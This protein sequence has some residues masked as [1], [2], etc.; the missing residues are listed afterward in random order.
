MERKRA[1]WSWALYDWANSA[2]ATT[3]M[4]GFF[5]IFLKLYWG[6]GVEP[7][8]T[9][10]YLGIG[11]SIASLVI[12]ILAP[13]LGA[14]ADNGGLKKRML[15]AFA[16]VG[17]IAT[18][19]LY[20]VELG[21][22]P[23][24]IL[25]YAIAVVGFSGANVF[26]DSLL[27]LVSAAHRRNRVSALGFSLGYLGGGLLFAVNVFMYLSPNTFGLSTG[28]EAI[29]WSFVTVAV[30]WAIFT[31]PILLWVNEPAPAS[32]R[33]RVDL[34]ASFSALAT[35]VRNVREYRVVWLFLLAYWLYI[36]GVDTIVRMAVDY[37]LNIGLGQ[38]SLIVA[39]L[40]VQFIG[41]PAALA[42]GRLG[43]RYGARR[44]IWICIW[45]YVG[46]TIFAYFMDSE[47]EMY[48]LAA[49][50]GLVQGG[51]QA[52]SRSLFSQLIPKEKSA[53][54]F[55]FYNVVGKA[56]AVFGPFLMGLVT[57]QTGDPR[58]GILSILIL[59]FAGMLVLRRVKLEEPI[60][61][62]S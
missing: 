33:R 6:N 44:G 1:I 60:N 49:I 19:T 14:M 15:S 61:R 17:V 34:A 7:S 55:G 39:L 40:M 38:E 59:F 22:W 58:T 45:A 35:T 52:L 11:N 32:D 43:D 53:E 46:I 47:L 41:F 3:V 28:S 36:D 8:L 37:G 18:G 2:F 42:F 16:C 50:I 5:P 31:I 56:A 25:L 51:I 57:I 21:M 27:V 48:I 54:F 9:T 12:V 13:V 4:A 62:Q 24:A 20:L 10:Y 23:L 29:R 26:Y 30:W